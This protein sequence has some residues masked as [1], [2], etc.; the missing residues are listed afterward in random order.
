LKAST[1]L[2]EP[3]EMLLSSLF[4]SWIDKPDDCSCRPS[5]PYAV[6]MKL[7]WVSLASSWH[8]VGAYL[9]DDSWRVHL[10]ALP[11]DVKV[12]AIVLEKTNEAFAQVL[13]LSA[14]LDIADNKTNDAEASE[15]TSVDFIEPT[16]HKQLL[17]QGYHVDHVRV[18]AFPLIESGLRLN[19]TEILERYVDG[20]SRHAVFKL[21]D[22][23][24]CASNDKRVRRDAD[25]L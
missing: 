19:T 6:Y 21:D 12:L 23:D 25:S 18:L 3:P 11:G 10:D 8:D 20:N 9:F 1:A 4:G 5:I 7:V 15:T 24:P 13:R 17:H 2:R 22:R 16:H 14:V